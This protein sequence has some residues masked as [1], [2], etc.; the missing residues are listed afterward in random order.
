MSEKT[1][2][3]SSST[4]MGRTSNHCNIGIRTLYHAK[5]YVE[6]DNDVI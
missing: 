3:R 6:Q 1:M 2:K 5:W 4:L